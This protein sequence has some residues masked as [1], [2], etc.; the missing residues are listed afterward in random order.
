[1][2]STDYIQKK[3]A[4]SKVRY[5]HPSSSVCFLCGSGLEQISTDTRDLTNL[6]EKQSVSIQVS[7]CKDASCPN[8]KKRLKPV[9]YLQQIVPQSGYGIDVYSKIGDLRIANRCTV[10]EIHQKILRDYSHI[11][12]T[13]RHVENMV[14]TLLL[15]IAQSGKNASY[16]KSYFAKRSQQQLQLTIDGVQPEQGHS[17]LYIVREAVS[18]KILFAHYSTHSDAKSLEKEI[19]APLQT[20]LEEAELEV[21]GWTADKELAISKAVLAVYPDTPFQHCQ[22]HFLA[23]MKKPL[24]HSDTELGKAVKKTLVNFDRLNGK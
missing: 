12:L 4:T 15:C 16:L 5:K 1:M 3:P 6:E 24:T 7:R 2:R 9:S 11:E 14:N 20:V 10:A 8:H 17:I 22:A 13:E 18:G 19:I 21:A 23:A